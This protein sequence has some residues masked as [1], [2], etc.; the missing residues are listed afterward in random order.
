MN[1]I[2]P[3]GLA[4]DLAAD[5]ARHGIV[6]V[7]LVG[8][9]Q[10]GID[11]MVQFGLMRGI[12]LG[13]ASGRRLDALAA[14]AATAGYR[15]DDMVI[16]NT[17]AAIDAAVES[18]RL[19]LSESFH[20]MCA[21]GHIDVIIDATGNPNTGS[22]IAIEA[23]RNGKHIVM[24]NVEADITIGRFLKAEAAKAGVVYT[25]AAGDEP[26]ATIEIIGFAQSLGLDIVAAG[27]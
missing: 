1:V 9:G 21:A 20:A 3:V 16:A 22:L 14:A 27:K 2:A 5:A 26:T 19:A 23:I 18:S 13:A 15:P 11:L 24:L 8:A 17:P 4:A 7:G 12:R 10:M 25:G 6:T